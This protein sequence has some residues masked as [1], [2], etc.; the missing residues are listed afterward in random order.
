MCMRQVV[1]YRKEYGSIFQLFL[2]T[3]EAYLVYDIGKLDDG[4]AQGG[5][6]EMPQ[7]LCPGSI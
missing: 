7:N 1:F 3:H 4:A 6:M 2:F 5:I